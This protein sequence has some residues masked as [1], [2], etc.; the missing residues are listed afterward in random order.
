M[1]ILVVIDNAEIIPAFY[2]RTQKKLNV[3]VSYHYLRGQASKLIVFYRDMINLLY[4]DSGAYSASTGRSRIT[5][6]EYL[7]YLKSYGHLF[8]EV[9]NFDDQFEDPQHNWKNQVILEN[10]LAGTGVKPIPVVHDP[11]KPFEEFEMYAKSGHDF[12]AIGSDKKLS[13]EVFEQIKKS[14]PT[15]KIHMF[16]TLNRKMLFKH[17]PYSADSSAY[18]KEAGT[19][20]ILYW[21]PIDKKE[22][23]IYVGAREKKGSNAVHFQ[24]FHHRANLEKFLHEK[25]KYSYKDLLKSVEAMWLVNIYFFTQLEDIINQSP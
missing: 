5:V 7:G 20:S 2:N 10:G 9:F 18:A 11:N 21:D 22:Y 12:I 16:G 23:S 15:I 14:Y 3:M 13:D 24:K 6:H 25:L 8:D 19:G 1:K 17:K 4:L